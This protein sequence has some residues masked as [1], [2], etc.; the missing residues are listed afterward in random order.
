MN[1][2]K[3]SSPKGV[4]RTGSVAGSSATNGERLEECLGSATKTQVS[5]LLCE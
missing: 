2:A 3:Y 4:K 1:M 5:V